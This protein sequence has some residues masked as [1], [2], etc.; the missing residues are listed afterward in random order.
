M[1]LSKRLARRLMDLQ[2]LPFIVVTNPH[3][4][5]VYEAYYHALNSLVGFPEV[6][7]QADRQTDRQTDRQ[8]SRTRALLDALRVCSSRLTV[9]V[10]QPDRQGL[11]HQAI[12]GCQHILQV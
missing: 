6:G 3:I 5:R 7:W 2:L 12:T 10:W 4:K 1:Q 11:H 8:G 9:S